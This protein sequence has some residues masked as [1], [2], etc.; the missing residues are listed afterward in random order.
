MENCF[1]S[2]EKLMH[3]LGF[4][5]D[6][7]FSNFGALT[8]YGAMEN[9]FDSTEKL[10]HISGFQASHLFPTF[11]CPFSLLFLENALF[12]LFLFKSNICD[13]ITEI[14]PRFPVFL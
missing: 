13:K 9:C 11:L 4:Q 6:H 7:S 3:I 8:N 10:M 2:T 1:D 12:L 14:F 5:A